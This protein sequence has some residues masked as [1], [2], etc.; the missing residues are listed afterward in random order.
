MLTEVNATQF[1]VVV[2]GQ[3]LAANIPSKQLADMFIMNLPADKRA[4][5]EAVPVTQDGKTVLFG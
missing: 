2:Q 3:V 4:L 1:N 5:A